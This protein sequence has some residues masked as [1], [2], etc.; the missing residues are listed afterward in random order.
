MY[1]LAYDYKCNCRVR[2]HACE[3][4][5]EMLALECSIEDNKSVNEP[6]VFENFQLFPKVML[7]FFF[8]FK[9]ISNRSTFANKANCVHNIICS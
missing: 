4:C 7:F 8:T 3:T 9:S 1:A 6:N 5:G 2:H